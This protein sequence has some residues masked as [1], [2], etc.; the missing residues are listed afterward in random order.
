MYFSV[1]RKRWLGLL[2]LLIIG[3]CVW[4]N[5]R[6]ESF[7]P[8]ALPAI[9]TTYHKTADEIVSTELYM[10]KITTGDNITYSSLINPKYSYTNSLTSND[11]TATTYKGL[12]ASATYTSSKTNYV[13]DYADSIA[14][15]RTRG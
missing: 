7:I 3:V 13:P 4:S 6:F 9:N 2:V 14:L 1:S 15:S 12:P 11:L 8:F 10:R 5:T